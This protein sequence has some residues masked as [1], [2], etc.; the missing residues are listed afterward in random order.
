MIHQL[1]L[2]LVS[3]SFPVP[4]PCVFIFHETLRTYKDLQPNIS[5]LPFP[6]LMLL[7]LWEYFH[8]SG[9]LISVAVHDPPSYLF[10]LFPVSVYS[11]ITHLLSCGPSDSILKHRCWIAIRNCSVFIKLKGPSL[12]NEQQ[13]EMLQ[14]QTSQ[15]ESLLH[16]SSVPPFIYVACNDRSP[17]G[18]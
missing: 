18:L 3:Q 2:I 16:I 8:L 7:C 15:W 6:F 9:N 13:K 10:T 14:F 5:S 4:H 17:L 12:K 1:F 11:P